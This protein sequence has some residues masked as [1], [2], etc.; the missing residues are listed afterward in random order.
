MIYKKK[1]LT[2]LVQLEQGKDQKNLVKLAR[3]LGSDHKI[4]AALTNKLGEGIVKR[5]QNDYKTISSYY[6]ALEK[7]YKYLPLTPAEKWLLENKSL[8]LENAENVK[9]TLSSQLVSRLPTLKSSP[10]RIRIITALIGLIGS[11]DFRLNYNRIWKFVEDYQSETKLTVA[12]LWSIPLVLKALLTDSLSYSLTDEKIIKDIVLGL[13]NLQKIDWGSFVEEVSIVDKILRHDPTGTYSLMDFRTRDSYRHVIEEV[14]FQTLHDQ[15]EIATWVVNESKKQNC[16]IG[17][18]LLGLGRDRI[19]KAFLPHRKLSEN[20]S[21]LLRRRPIK[22]YLGLTWAAFLGFFITMQ[23]LLGLPW[24]CLFLMVFPSFGLANLITHLVVVRLYPPAFLPKMDSSLPILEKDRTMVLTPTLLMPDNKMLANLEENFLANRDKNIFFGVAL[25]WPQTTANGGKPSPMELAALEFVKKEISDL[26]KKYPAPDPRFHLFFR[27]R[28]WSTDEQAWVEW[29]RKRGKIIDFVH[30]LRNPTDSSFS[31]NTGTPEFLVSI[32][33]VITV[34]DDV[35]LPRDSAKK[36]IA[37][38]IHPLNLPVIDKESQTV[39]RGYGIIQPRISTQLADRGKSMANYIFEGNS[40]WDSYS[41][42]AS[43]VYQDIFR[44]S[45]FMGRGIFDVDTF[46]KILT[47]RFPENTLLSHD[48]IEGF[49]CRTGFASDI[50]LFETSPSTYSAYCRRL[51]RWVRGDWQ[52]LFWILPWVGNEKGKIEKNPLT[53]YHRWK[54]IE[55]L[56]QNLNFPATVFLT[57]LLLIVFPQKQVAGLILFFLVF[58]VNPTLALL[59]SIPIYKD[60]WRD[61]RHRLFILREDLKIFFAKMLFYLVFSL[62]QAIIIS[63]AI[64]TAL[65]R[66]FITKRKRLEWATFTQTNQNVGNYTFKTGLVDSFFPILIT[67]GLLLVV[68]GFLPLSFRLIPTLLLVAW[69]TMPEVI[70]I[71]NRQPKKTM[72]FSKDEEQNLRIIARKT[73]RYFDDLVGKK[74]NFLPPDHF[75]QTTISPISTRT[76]ATDIGMY[77]TSIVAAFDLGFITKADALERFTKT[78]ATLAKLDLLHGHFFNWYDIATLKAMPPSYVST[79]DSGNLACALL[80][81]ATALKDLPVAPEKTLRAAGDLLAIAKQEADPVLAG[82]LGRLNSLAAIQTEINGIEVDKNSELGYWIGKIKDLVA[83]SNKPNDQVK[84]TREC[85]KLSCQAEKF[86]MD[87]DFS[88]LFD[89]K[90][91]LFKIGFNLF[92]KTFDRNYYDMFASESRMASLFAIAKYEAPLKHWTT[93]ARPMTAY[94]AKTALLSWGGS[95]FEYLFPNLFLP[96]YQNSLLAETYQTV[97]SGHIDYG[98]KNRIPW[99]ISE[100]SYGL[101]NKDGHYRYKLHGVPDFGL[102]QFSYKDLVVT[103]YAVFLAMEISPRQAYQN[104]RWLEK[105][106]LLNIYGLYESI[107][108]TSYES[109]PIPDRVIKAYLCHHQGII[110]SAITNMLNNFSIRDRLSQTKIIKAHLSLLQEP[111]LRD[112]S[113]S[114][115][116]IPPETDVSEE[117]TQIPEALQKSVVNVVK[118]RH[119]PQFNL[120]S[121]GRY[122]VYFDDRGGGYSQYQNFRLTNW[123]CDPTFDLWGTFFYLKDVESQQVWSAT[124][125]PTSTLPEKYE[126]S[127]SQNYG[128]ITRVNAGIETSIEVVVPFDSDLEIRYLTIK[129]LSNKKRLLEVTN[130]AEVV[131]DN[132]NSAQQHPVFSKMRVE[133]EYHEIS[134]TL[135]FH[136]LARPTE[137]VPVFA[138]RVVGS[139]KIKYDTDRLKVLGRLGSVEAPKAA[140]GSLGF[141]LDPVICWQLAVNLDPRSTRTLAFLYASGYGKEAAFA[142][143]DKYTSL[144]RIEEVIEF[145]KSAAIKTE[146]EPIN[147]R[148]IQQTL[149]CLMYGRELANEKYTFSALTKMVRPKLTIDWVLPTIVVVVKSAASVNF[150][151]QGLNL[152]YLISNLGV[153]F[154]VIIVVWDSDNYYQTTHNTVVELANEFEAKAVTNNLMSPNITILRV[155]HLSPKEVRF[156]VA[157]ASIVWNSAKGNV[158]AQVNIEFNKI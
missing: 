99:G 74:S 138:S 148:I 5:L 154:N 46:D 56:I 130:Y 27:N 127:F 60:F 144:E 68:F 88:F 18:F 62:H 121:N 104:I 93:L 145:T 150:I 120:L 107:D 4:L 51:H 105:D 83:Q 2:P 157:T 137:N 25:S 158:A 153:K 103:P 71:V 13:R 61:W 92:N 78:F 31:F 90:R 22:V 23:S 67:I 116:Q 79:V 40:G 110:L 100:S 102:K 75:Q 89:P 72:P 55:D 11:S 33:Y 126:V 32:K 53:P 41:N 109:G 52:R 97:V 87:M 139:E 30:L 17:Y 50:T 112:V 77:L 123:V 151:R 81:C 58:M 131:L 125:G 82:Q 111:V 9:K 117:Q 94:K 12:E 108:Y 147:Q 44:E 29:E 114:V 66:I 48:H 24:W 124:L 14:H 152:S 146:F 69:L 134:K 35:T 34:D 21:L 140:T 135:L 84:F 10:N 28:K 63:G 36:L 101:M 6:K 19:N 133:S 1:N 26:N 128:K 76:S 70:V 57:L 95:V 156:L 85:Q 8:V 65:V 115:A 122:H 43:N 3:E 155:D 86:A 45:F 15:A 96:N 113:F 64:V 91:N 47:G 38:I 129:N 49:Y 73:W 142:N 59:E 118:L 37:T 136:R 80:V 143:L 7:K 149:T 106:G 42:V 98:Q 54:L 16:H 132:P 119:T 141:T 39:T 20:F